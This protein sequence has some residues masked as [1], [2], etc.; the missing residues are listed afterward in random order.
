MTEFTPGNDPALT[1]ILAR[2]DGAELFVADSGIT[3]AASRP[4]G[5]GP[6]IMGPVECI[7]CGFR[8]V[9]VIPESD[10]CYHAEQGYIDM[11]ECTRCGKHTLCSE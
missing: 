3:A 4:D 8:A 1:D 7:N 5:P 10:P 9:A 6:W 11:L 2:A